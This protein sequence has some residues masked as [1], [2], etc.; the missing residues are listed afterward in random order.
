MNEHRV[1]QIFEVSLLLKGAHALVECVGAVVLAFVS[2]NAIVSLA[3]SLTQ[4]ELVE[5]PMISSPAI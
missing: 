2:T 3:N 4:E 1:H 5:D